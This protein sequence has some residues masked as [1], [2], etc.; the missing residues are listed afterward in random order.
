[1]ADD[2]EMTATEETDPVTGQQEERREE[3]PYL[4][5]QNQQEVDTWIGKRLGESRKLKEKLESLA[6]KAEALDKIMAHFGVDDPEKLNDLLQDGTP[7][8]DEKAPEEGEETATAMQAAEVNLYEALQA[9]AE[10]L[11]SFDPT[12]YSEVDGAALLKDERFLALVGQG[13]GV[14][15][16]YDACHIDE[17]VKKSIQR[18]RQTLVANI[19]TRGSRPTENAM[20]P[21]PYSS[22]TAGV[23]ALTDEEIAALAQ[24]A[25]KGQK[26]IL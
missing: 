24:R 21:T 10:G 8:S 18:E 17:L 4:S 26:I 6:P 20:A 11:K 25:R 5:F 12:L 9:E 2:M 3:R 15:E 1:M 23:A 13:F 19:M 14:K 7:L 16:A 22:Q